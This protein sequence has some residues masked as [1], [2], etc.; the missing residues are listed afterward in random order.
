MNEEQEKKILNKIEEHN[1]YNLLML[2]IL[3][4]L[5]IIFSGTNMKDN[6]GIEN[7]LDQII[8]MLDGGELPE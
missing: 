8:L 5:V 2:W 1:F 6:E 3:V 4:V 7:K